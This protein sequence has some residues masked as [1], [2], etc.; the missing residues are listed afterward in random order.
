MKLFELAHLAF[1]APAEIAVSGIPQIEARNLLEAARCIKLCRQLV[2][3]AL[4]L[5]WTM[6]ARLLNGTLVRA[7]GIEISIFNPGDFG[8]NQSHRT[9]EGLRDAL[10]PLAKLLPVLL[11]A[12]KAFAA[13]LRLLGRD[14]RGESEC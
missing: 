2:G 14:E 11:D 3:E 1:R 8:L 13:P 6:L 9:Y 10:H 5:D 7:H 12:A 4:V